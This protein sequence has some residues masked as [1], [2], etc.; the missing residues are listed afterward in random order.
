[1]VKLNNELN[2][3]D[4][5]LLVLVLFRFLVFIIVMQCF[6]GGAVGPRFTGFGN[7][8]SHTSQPPHFLPSLKHRLLHTLT[9]KMLDMAPEESHEFTRFYS[10]NN[11]G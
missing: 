4:Q 9:T 1:M 8:H 6:E 2:G 7:I 5:Q 11:V 10:A 3:M